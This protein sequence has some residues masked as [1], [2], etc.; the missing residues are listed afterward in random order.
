MSNNAS[1]KVVVA[2]TSVIIRSGLTAVLKRMPNLNIHPVEVT[3]AEALDN[4]VQLHEPDIVI[5]NPMFCGLFDLQDFK[6]RHHALTR[7]K[8]VA[9]VNSVIG[10]D[11]LKEYD[12]S[13][14][15]SSMNCPHNEL[16]ILYSN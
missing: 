14:A 1:L 2:E 12:E 5:V 9:M 16:I 4:Y 11:V 13:I 15:I 8:C 10:F 3:S 7:M 6:R